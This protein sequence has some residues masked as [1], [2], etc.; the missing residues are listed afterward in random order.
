MRTSSNDAGFSG[1]ATAQLP[2]QGKQ[3]GGQPRPQRA[4]GGQ[5]RNKNAAKHHLYSRD[6]GKVDLRRREDRAVVQTLAALEADL[7]DVSAQ[8]AL[9]LAGI[10]RKLRDL[11]K[12]EEYLDGLSSIVNKR[13]KDLLPIVAKKHQLLESIRRDL[14]S[15]GLRRR[16]KDV[17]D[18]GRYLSERYGAQDAPNGR[19]EDNGQASSKSVQQEPTEARGDG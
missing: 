4:G 11:A 15:I 7:G 8:E 6:A 14:E 5:P 16:T 12:I 3:R 18:I 19:A 17:P 10:G 1:A 13:R 2:P 9:I